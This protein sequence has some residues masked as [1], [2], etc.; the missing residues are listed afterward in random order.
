MLWATVLILFSCQR[1]VEKKR[2]NSQL[3]SKIKNWLDKQKSP[4]QPNKASNIDLLK[5]NLNFSASKIEYLNENEQF[6]VIPINETY[7]IKKNIEVN[8]STVLLLVWDKAEN[9]LRGNIV[10]YYP[11]HN[12]QVNTIPNNTFYK[13]YSEKNLD[14]NGLFRFLSPTGRWMYQREY[15]NGKLSSFGFVKVGDKQERTATDCTHYYLI[16][17]WWVDGVPVNQEAIYLGSICQGGCDD[18]MNQTLCPDNGGGGGGQEGETPCCIPD[19][20]AQI[21]FETG[22]ESEWYCSTENTDP[23]S[24]NLTKNCTHTWTFHRNHLLWYSWDFVSRTLAN[25]EKI[26]GAWK[27][28]TS[29]SPVSPSFQGITTSGQLPP[30]ISSKCIDVTPNLS[31]PSNKESGK[32]ILSYTVETK[33]LCFSWATPRYDPSTVEATLIPPA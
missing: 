12:Q 20:N 2:D 24:G 4:N 13:M 22:N 19:P 29:S 10:L 7:K 18:P 23:V 28:K 32:L 30:C 17:T 5:E 31:V 1:E 3:I 9:I 14:C 33:F 26:G 21:T 8:T 25:F 16:L 27:F 11:E 6:I 15:K